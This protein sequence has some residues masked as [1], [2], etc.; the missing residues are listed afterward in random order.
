[1]KTAAKARINLILLLVTLGVNALGAL[2]YINGLSQRVVSDRYPTF[3][4][5]SPSSFSIWSVIYTLLLLSM[6]WMVVRSK[7]GKAAKTIEAISLPFQVSS[8]LNI[9]WIVTF[10]YEW[11]GLSTLLIFALVVSL[12]VVNLRLKDS[13]GSGLRLLGLSFGLYNGWLLIASVVNASA[14]LVK[15]GWNGFGLLP[16]TW[17]VI[18]LAAA[19]LVAAAVLLR[20]RNAAL[21][22][23]I[24]WAY[25]GIRQVH[26]AGGVYAGAYPSIATAAL[27]GCVAL[28]LLAAAVFL[29]NGRCLLPKEKVFPREAA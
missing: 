6:I 8:A 25:F 7:D 21:A 27:I 15:Q 4:T 2:G 29:W 14:F 28:V 23:P 9:L 10:S 13:G 22:L 11:I 20:L 24:A 17:A 16:Q 1:M 19:P 26:L 5:P 18:M 12:A 3:I